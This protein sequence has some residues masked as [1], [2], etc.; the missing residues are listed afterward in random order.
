[1]KSSAETLATAI[2]VLDIEASAINGL[3]QFIDNSFYEAVRLIY[4]STGRVVVTG[5]GKSAIIGNKIVATMNSTGT[6]AIFMHAADAVHG[7]LG[8]VQQDDVVLCISNSGNTPEI[9]LLIPLVKSGGNKLISMSGNKESYLAK[10]SDISLYA[11]VAQ[12][13]CPNN[14]APTSSTTAQL[15]LGDALAVALLDWK[16]FSAKDFARYHPGGALGKRLYLRV[17]DIYLDNER[18]IVKPDADLKTVIMEI[19][20]KRLGATVVSE[21]GE[22]IDGIITDGDLRR[23]LSRDDR[24]DALQAK[25]IMSQMASTVQKDAMATEALDIMRHKKITQLIVL[26]G[27][28]Y[29]GM[30][31]IHDLNK[32]GLIS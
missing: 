22:H 4:E 5:I 32:Q 11:I 21:D 28:K 19:S 24:P 9:K 6:P 31:H 2:Q 30:V 16:D 29:L 3:K 14:L 13:A 8:M 17:S 12:E 18:P 26:D 15:A 25:D 23:L 27:D 20:S 7:D 10:E 1:M